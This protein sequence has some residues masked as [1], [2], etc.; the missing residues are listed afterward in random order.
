M[1][2]SILAIPMNPSSSEDMPLMFKQNTQM[3]VLQF[4]NFIPQYSSLKTSTSRCDEPR[5]NCKNIIREKN[6]S[7]E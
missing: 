3:F 1:F 5:I 6:A 7:L 2:Q 4:G